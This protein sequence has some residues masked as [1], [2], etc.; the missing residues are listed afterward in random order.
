MIIRSIRDV[1]ASVHGRRK[2][3][4]M[5]QA[6]LAAKAGVSRKWIY[7]FEAGKP[8][9]EFGR[10][11]RVIEALG[12]ELGV[13]LRSGDD[14]LGRGDTVNLDDLLDEYRRR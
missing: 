9:A 7:E 6:E 14:R 5:S 8:T 13:E 11:L 10:L 3:L 1:A 4:A 2:D 12:L